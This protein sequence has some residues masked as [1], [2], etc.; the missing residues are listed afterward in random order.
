MT[1]K[2]LFTIYKIVSGEKRARARAR[3]RERE[4]YQYNKYKSIQG[5]APKL[6]SGW[7]CFFLSLSES[8]E[9]RIPALRL[10]FRILSKLRFFN[11]K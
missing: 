9:T 7:H 10:G 4:A 3:A 1:L 6:L 11:C 2:C 8:K 5:E